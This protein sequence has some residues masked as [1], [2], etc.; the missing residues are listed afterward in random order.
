M[1]SKEMWSL[2]ENLETKDIQLLVTMSIRY[3]EYNRKINFKKII[4]D[5]ENTKKLLD[6]RYSYE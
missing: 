1:N 3:L 6:V 5:I 2:L 4:K